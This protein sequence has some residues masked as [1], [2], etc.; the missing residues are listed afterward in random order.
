MLGL[1][2]SMQ[3]LLCG[4]YCLKQFNLPDCVPT[5]PQQSL[6]EDQSSH[7]IAGMEGRQT[8]HLRTKLRVNN[9]LFVES[10]LFD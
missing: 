10:I 8:S 2:L 9:V 4:S 3:F 7:L 1:V 5:S 6:Q